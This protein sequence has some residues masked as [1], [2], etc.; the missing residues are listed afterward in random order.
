MIIA[1]SNRAAETRDPSIDP[2]FVMSKIELIKTSYPSYQETNHDT[3]LN[4]QFRFITFSDPTIQGIYFISLSF[5]CWRV[6]KEHNCETDEVSTKFI[7]FLQL[8]L[9]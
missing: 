2:E 4:S 3:N 5:R 9:N 7:Y 8:C 1:S 6:W